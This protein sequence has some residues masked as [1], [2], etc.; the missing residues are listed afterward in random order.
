MGVRSWIA[1]N[2]KWR[3]AFAVGLCGAWSLQ[4]H[5]AKASQVII[6]T[7]FQSGYEGMFTP[8]GRRPVVSVSPSCSGGAS[9]R[10]EAAV[11]SKR[12]EFVF[13]E[14]KVQYN[15]DYWFAFSV[16]IPGEPGNRKENI[17]TV[18]FQLHGR[19]DKE[20]GERYRS[21][22]VSVAFMDGKIKLNLWADSKPN[23]NKGKGAR[24]SVIPRP[25]ILGDVRENSWMDFVIHM[26]VDYRQRG[27]GLFQIWVNGE[28]KYDYKGQLGYNDKKPPYIKFGNYTPRFNNKNNPEVVGVSRVVYYDN[29]TML[30]G[31][32]DSATTIDPKCHSGAPERGQGVDIKPPSKLE[33][34]IVR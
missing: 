4:M 14:N 27:D 8:Q 16:L 2:E 6:Q 5:A 24:H 32:N 1:C 18:F 29:F 11:P 31:Y 7:N 9:V 23:S 25:T 10:F 26:R 20:L 34:N 22:M 17:S 13:R 28:K 12:S 19:P 15:E 3:A 21:P 33:L 30:A